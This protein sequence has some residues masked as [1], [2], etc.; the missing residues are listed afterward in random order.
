LEQLPLGFWLFDAVLHQGLFGIHAWGLKVRF[1]R[2]TIALPDAGERS[3]K[4]LA[5]SISG[6]H[7]PVAV[8]PVCRPVSGVIIN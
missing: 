6:I 2:P 5:R 1:Q 4:G 7:K 8:V 3:L